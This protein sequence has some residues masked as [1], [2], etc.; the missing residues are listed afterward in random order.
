V[1]N[2]IYY[3]TSLYMETRI[4][5]VEMLQAKYFIKVVQ[6][7]CP[8]KRFQ[9]LVLSDFISYNSGNKIDKITK[10]FVNVLYHL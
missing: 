3:K 9:C 5:V 2:Y 10:I 7:Q 1:E 4:C 6:I 8:T